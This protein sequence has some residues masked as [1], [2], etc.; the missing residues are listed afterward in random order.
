ML[1]RRLFLLYI[2]IS[3]DGRDAPIRSILDFVNHSLGFLTSLTALLCAF[4]SAPS[5]LEFKS[6]HTLTLTLDLE[7]V[8]EKLFL[9]FLHSVFNCDAVPRINLLNKPRN[10]IMQGPR[11]SCRLF[12]T[13]VAD[14]RYSLTLVLCVRPVLGFA[15]VSDAVFT[16]KDTRNFFDET[17]R[18]VTYNVI[19]VDDFKRTA[20]H[21]AF[22]FCLIQLFSQVA[23]KFFSFKLGSAICGWT[24]SRALE[25]L[26]NT[27]L[28]KRLTTLAAASG[29]LVC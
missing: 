16:T 15:L 17:S 26:S 5:K 14:N 19:V 7:L 1:L 29:R 20:F 22:N 25:V 24:N 2:I 8:R 18:S 9:H 21:R 23:H 10:A 11:C 6:Y 4:V 27:G 12:L 28:A 3:F 13:L